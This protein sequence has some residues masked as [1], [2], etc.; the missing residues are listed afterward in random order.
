MQWIKRDS[1][2][3]EFEVPGWLIFRLPP[4]FGATGY[5]HTYTCRDGLMANPA[6]L[7]AISKIPYS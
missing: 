4:P 2:I 3:S 6:Q 5:I 7:S 1:P